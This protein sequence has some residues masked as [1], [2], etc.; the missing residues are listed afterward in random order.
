VSAAAPRTVALVDGLSVA[1]RRRRRLLRVLDDVSFALHA[2][3]A[4]GL[5]GESGCGKTTA[6]MALMRY[7]PRNAVVEAGAITFD[8]VD[9][10]AVGERELRRLRGDRMAMVYQDPGSA[11]N[12]ALTVG[13]QIAEVYELHRGLDRRAARAAAAARALSA[14]SCK[15]WIAARVAACSWG[16]PPPMSRRAQSYHSA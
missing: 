3:E 15:L 13:A 5:V 4:F 12:P 7:L 11:L 9:L 16:R 10:L 6:A 14:P 1:Y 2:G 8:G